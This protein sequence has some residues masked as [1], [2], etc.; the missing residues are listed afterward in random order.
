MEEKVK[1]IHDCLKATSDRQKSY[2]DLKQK[3]I[4]FQVGDKVFLKLSPWKKVLRFG[5]K[6][7]LSPR[8]IGPYEITE[9]IGPV[10]YQLA[11][12]SKLERIHDVFYVSMLH[13]Y[14][15][16]LHM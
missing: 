14:R 6:G 16:N 9:R 1:I 3:E 13:R 12:P 15:S 4:E 11:L 2:A 10:A 8:F 5:R 7:K